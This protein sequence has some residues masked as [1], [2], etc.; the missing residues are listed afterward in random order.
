MRAHVT[1][2][3]SASRSQDLRQPRRI[4][5]PPHA[6]TKA[7]APPPADETSTDAPAVEETAPAPPARQ[8]RT[9]PNLL[10]TWHGRHTNHAAQLDVTRQ[11]GDTFQ[12]TMRV[13]TPEASV[14]L[15]VEG[16]VSKSGEVSM[17]ERRVLSSTAPRAWDLGS[18]SGHVAGDGKITGTGTDV[19]GR[20]GAWS[21]S[22]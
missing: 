11:N 10:G 21:F 15:A 9:G 22:R 16:R 20:V 8:T 4:E 6:P 14:L 7:P 13:R 1:Q 17:R 19:K 12:G 18:E 5:S 3:A 2:V